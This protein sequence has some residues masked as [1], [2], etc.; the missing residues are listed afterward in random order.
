[1]SDTNDRIIAYC[2]ENNEKAGTFIFSR[3]ALEHH[4]HRSIKGDHQIRSSSPTDMM[5]SP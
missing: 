1:M 2:R 4:V 3:F 5:T